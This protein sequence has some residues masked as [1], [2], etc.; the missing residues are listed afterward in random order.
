MNSRSLPTL[1]YQQFDADLSLDVSAEAYGGWRKED[2]PFS[3]KHTALVVMHAWDIGTPAEKPGWFRAVEYLPRSYSIAETVFPPLLDAA[4]RADLTVAHVVGGSDYYSHLPGYEGSAAPTVRRPKPDPVYEELVDY[5]LTK[6]FPGAHNQADIDTGQ[7]FSPYAR[8]LGDEGVAAN[9]EQLAAL[10]EATG[11]NHLVYV[12]F[13]LNVCLL[14]SAGGMVDMTRRGYLCSTI[15][16]ATTAVEN[17]ETARA[18]LNLAGAL[19]RVAVLHGFVYELDDF[20]TYLEA[21]S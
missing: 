4:R 5:R 13:A 11:I 15:R 9:S 8:P 19:W 6:V 20:M 7:D 17:K 21:Q 12:G 3:M 10:C 18:E 1:S 14:S 16:G 2:L